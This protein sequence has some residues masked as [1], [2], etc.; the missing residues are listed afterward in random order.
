MNL[1]T[2]VRI[3]SCSSFVAYFGWPESTRLYDR[4]KLKQFSSTMQRAFCAPAVGPIWQ[5]RLQW[6]APS[7]QYAFRG[8]YFCPVCDAFRARA[9]GE[10]GWKSVLVLKWNGAISALLF[11]TIPH[12]ILPEPTLSLVAPFSFSS[13]LFFFLPTEKVDGET[14]KGERKDDGQNVGGKKKRSY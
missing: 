1:T 5:Q 10:A 2:R 8:Q 4:A 7:D 6:A 11:H 3:L 12:S 9:G 14:A 13:L